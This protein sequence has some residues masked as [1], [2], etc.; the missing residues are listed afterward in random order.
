MRFKVRDV[1]NLATPD[2]EEHTINSSELGE[3][4]RRHVSLETSRGRGLL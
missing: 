1:S 4:E 2:T 3:G